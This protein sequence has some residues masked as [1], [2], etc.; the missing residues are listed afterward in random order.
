MEW[1]ETWAK[2]EFLTVP[3]LTRIVV[4]KAIA[5]YQ[6]QHPLETVED[7]PEPE[8]TAKSATTASKTKGRKTTK[9]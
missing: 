7:V 1:L 9:S 6:K 3:Q 4:K 5:E 2:K 8:P